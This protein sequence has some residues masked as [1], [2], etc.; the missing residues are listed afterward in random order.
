[1][2]FVEFI[3]V[4]DT[5][6]P[7]IDADINLAKP[8]SVIS[9][10]GELPVGVEIELADREPWIVTSDVIIPPSNKNLEP[11]IPPSLFKI[12]PPVELDICDIPI[13]KPPILP[14]VA[15]TLPTTISPSGFTWNLEEL[16]SILPFE[17]LTN[18][19]SPPKKNL[20]PNMFTLEPL[21]NT[22][23]DLRT[24]DLLFTPSPPVTVWPNDIRLLSSAL[25]KNPPLADMKAVNSLPLK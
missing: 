5:S 6:N 23:S 15:F 17:P 10:S 18:W 9:A 25:N 13:S 22:L 14:S 4:C 2:S 19:E 21:K 20:S 8:A 11:V 16:I 3:C 7:P 12:R 24:N 1:M